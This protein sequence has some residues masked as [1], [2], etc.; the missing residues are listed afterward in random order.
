M[1]D[2]TDQEIRELLDK[3]AIHDTL[4]RYC[5]GIDRCDEQLI[6]SAYHPG[7]YD[8]HGEFRG[9]VEEFV[10]WVLDALQQDGGMVTMHSICNEYVEVR[11]DVAYGEA[12]FIAYHRSGPRDQQVDMTLGARYIDR[13]ERRGGQWKIT[14]RTVVHDWNRVDPVDRIHDRIHLYRQ[15]V[16][17]REDE[18][19][20]RDW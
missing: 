10:P 14:R 12:Y 8:D 4:M 1:A 13:Y 17:T 2:F 16:R 5:R 20:R 11:G 9:T 19:Y 6:R 15:G 7:A 3:Q 18:S